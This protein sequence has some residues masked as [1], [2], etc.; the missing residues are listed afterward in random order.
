[1]APL[2]GVEPEP[3]RAAA[4]PTWTFLTN[5]GHVLVALSR[6]PSARVRDLAGTVGI[7]ERATMS[8]LADLEDAGYVTRRKHGRRNSYTLHP[9]Q[10]M[11]HPAESQHQVGE[12]LALF[13][14]TSDAAT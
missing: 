2:D 9:T 14:D 8:I 5:H 11:R 6:I 12:L 1:V 4:V 7:T 3:A 13:A 10:C